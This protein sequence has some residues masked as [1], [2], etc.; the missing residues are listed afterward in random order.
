MPTAD[1]EVRAMI[2]EQVSEARSRMPDPHEVLRVRCMNCDRPLLRPRR[3]VEKMNLIDGF[4]SCSNPCR[5]K[6]MEIQERVASQR[7][8]RFPETTK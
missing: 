7:V 3:V 5:R 2:R 8:M 4:V 6:H 1:D